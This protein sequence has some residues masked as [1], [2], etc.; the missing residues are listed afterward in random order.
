MTYGL[1][2]GFNYNSILNHA[3]TSVLILISQKK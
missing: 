3:S 2:L 1:K